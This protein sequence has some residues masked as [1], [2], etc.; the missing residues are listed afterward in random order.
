[1]IVAKSVSRRPLVLQ[2]EEVLSTGLNGRG[3]ELE[4]LL[5]ALESIDQAVS[6]VP[7]PIVEVLLRARC[8]WLSE[9]LLTPIVPRTPLRTLAQ[10]FLNSAARKRS[11]VFAAAVS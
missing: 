1:M 2:P 9:G 6:E 4:E 11:K 10:A 8:P 7:D 5:E 3:E